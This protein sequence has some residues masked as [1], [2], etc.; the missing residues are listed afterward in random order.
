[1]QT[2]ETPKDLIT[3]ASWKMPRILSVGYPL[4]VFAAVA[5]VII[6][7]PATPLA[8][9]GVAA[10][11]LAVSLTTLLVGT[12]LW[13]KRVAAQKD[14]LAPAVQNNEAP[15]PT[16]NKEPKMSAQSPAATVE[17][18]MTAQE[19]K[20]LGDAARG[21]VIA[22]GA[23]LISAFALSSDAPKAAEKSDKNQPQTAYVVSPAILNEEE[24]RREP[25]HPKKSGQKKAL[26]A[27]FN[28]VPRVIGKVVNKPLGQK[29]PQTHIKRGACNNLRQS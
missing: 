7:A 18:T 28:I 21:F 23:F 8:L 27:L 16:Q 14:A 2:T 5:A 10:A 22:V 12:T 24:E 19:E 17:N 4:A 20:T 29:Y 11:G 26:R 1:M 13:Q 9:L 15:Q 3:T 6:T 25:S